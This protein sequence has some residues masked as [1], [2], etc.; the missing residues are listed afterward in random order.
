M[1]ILLLAGLLI[2]APALA[3]T[4]AA[5]L[6]RA[7]A[8]YG[9]RDYPAARAAF[10]ALADQG[11]AIGETMLGT[12]YANGEGVAADPATAVAYWWRAANRGYA[13]AQLALA[14]ALAAGRGVAR[15]PGAAWLWAELAAR[16]GDRDIVAAATRLAASMAKAAGPAVVAAQRAKLEAWRP[17][18]VASQ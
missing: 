14:A 13:P 4:P 8:S 6:E 12:M 7:L 16:T 5:T 1:K 11:S 17:W 3:E 15:N 10:V 2:A 18:V 9:A